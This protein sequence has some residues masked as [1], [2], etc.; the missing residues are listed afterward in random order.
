MLL[1]T[2]WNFLFIKGQKVASTSVE[3]ALSEHCGPNDIITP[4]TPIDEYMR[5][6]TGGYCRNYTRDKQA[7]ADYL[8]L[9]RDEKGLIDKIPAA[10][11]SQQIYYNHMPYSRVVEIVKQPLG[12]FFR[13]TV[14]RHPYE[15]ALS[16]ANMSLS[17]R[18]YK[19][20]QRLQPRITDILQALDR[21]IEKGSLVNIRNF[22]LY[23]INGMSMMDRIIRYE[24]LETELADVVKILGIPGPVKLPVT[25]EGLRDKSR[26]AAELLTADQKKIIQQICREEFELLEYAV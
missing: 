25:K 15:K 6:D 22:D 12:Q 7:E 9:I 24:N 19:Q 8:E 11:T 17:F 26:S 13:F 4:I 21:L 23:S 3:I 18:A 20:G 5:L 2:K 16:L 10:V 1:S 14:E